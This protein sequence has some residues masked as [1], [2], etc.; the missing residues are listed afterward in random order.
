MPF[1]FEALDNQF[2][3]GG[4]YN[5]RPE[6]TQPPS[7]YFRDQV[8]STFWFEEGATHLI[9]T[10]VSADNIMFE[11]DFPHPT[12]LYDNVQEK[13]AASIGHLSDELRHK[14]LWGNAAKV[15]GIRG[16]AAA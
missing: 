1:M 3:E 10:H 11:T 5:E 12:C 6:F 15:Y 2:R 7:H 4:G 9:G 14:V 8:Y 13:L 16:P